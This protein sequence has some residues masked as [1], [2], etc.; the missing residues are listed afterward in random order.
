[1]SFFKNL[2]RRRP[3]PSSFH[4]W[5]VQKLAEITNMKKEM[6]FFKNLTRRRPA[7]SSFHTWMSKMAPEKI[8]DTSRFQ[9]M[10]K[11]PPEKIV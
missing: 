8:V 9:K 2:T 3:A 5:G 6:S 10:P 1:M 7:P 11:M 4:A